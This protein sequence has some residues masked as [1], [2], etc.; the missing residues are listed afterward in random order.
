MGGRSRLPATLILRPLTGE[1]RMPEAHT[2]FFQLDVPRYSSLD[3]M[4]DK[5][6]F[7][8]MSCTEID[9]DGGGGVFEED[10]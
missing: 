8:V 5:V 10:D 6:I 7:A 3:V 9:T 2:C 1:D 4:T